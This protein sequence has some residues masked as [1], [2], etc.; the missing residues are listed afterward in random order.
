MT[1]WDAASLLMMASFVGYLLYTL[2]FAPP[3]PEPPP[4]SSEGMRL[5][6]LRAHADL[7]WKSMVIHWEPWVSA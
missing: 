5:A 2:F 6:S 3:K 7:Y 1:I 4:L